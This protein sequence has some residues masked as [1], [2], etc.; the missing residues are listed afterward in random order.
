M[1]IFAGPKMMRVQNGALAPLANHST[2]SARTP[3]T[4]ECVYS[5]LQC[6]NLGPE[7]RASHTR[8]PDVLAS[9]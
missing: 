1:M 7:E 3:T 5:N 8:T 9:R 4:P 2:G 6:L